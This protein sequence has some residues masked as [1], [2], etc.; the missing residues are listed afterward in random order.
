MRR[1]PGIRL[2]LGP[3]S[4]LHD[5]A[6]IIMVPVKMEKKNILAQLVIKGLRDMRP[7][8]AMPAVGHLVRRA[9]E[10]FVKQEVGVHARIRLHKH[11][12]SS[13]SGKK[14]QRGRYCGRVVEE[15]QDV[16][17]PELSG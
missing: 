13:F 9:A 10:L 1:I 7:E 12:R 11:G 3:L 17:R 2:D 14:K 15:L 5:A 16:L 4:V 8:L 6:V